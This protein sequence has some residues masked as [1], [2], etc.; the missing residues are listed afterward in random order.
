VRRLARIASAVALALGAGGAAAS[1]VETLVDHGTANRIH[2]AILGDGYTSTQQAQLSDDARGLAGTLLGTPPFDRYAALFTI[3]LVHLMSA[4]QGA[5]TGSPANTALHSYFGCYGIDRLLCTDTGA[6]FV[7]ASD[8]YP[9][10][11]AVIV[12]VNDT[13]YGGA[14]GNVTTVSRNSASA[15]ILLHE[16]GHSFGG[17]ADEYTDPYPGYPPCSQTTDCSEP[18]VT[19]R[20]TRAQIPW[21]S[22]IEPDVPI[23]TPQGAGFWAVGL[24]EGARF[25]TTGVYRPVDAAC[26]MHQLGQDYCPVCTEALVREIWNA[27]TP[28]EATAPAPGAVAVSAC[29]EADFAAYAVPVATPLSV[30]WTVDGAPAGCTGQQLAFPPGALTA[31]THAIEAR[32]S[33][34]TALVR[35]DP[36]GLLAEA[37]R[38][39]VQVSACAS[40][41]P[42]PAAPTCSREELPAGG[43]ASPTAGRA[44]GTGSAATDGTGGAASAAAAGGGAGASSSCG[45]GG[46]GGPGGWAALAGAAVLAAWRRPRRVSPRTRTAAAH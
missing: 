16:L 1:D 46:P 27:V 12:L 35:N 10:Y 30:T 34:G 40:A 41:V 42:A 31:G 44:P 17:L 43:G 7:A 20:T 25:L 4:Q 38:W 9:D 32:V 45:T 8:A 13:R 5:G 11:D 2:V 39:T 14:G 18:N 28:L 19:L 15:E 6:A 33:D 3:R 37:A 22:W 29:D 26:R 21:A 36:R 23:P 24:F